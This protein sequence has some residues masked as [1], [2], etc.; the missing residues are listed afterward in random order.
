MVL[1]KYHI[2]NC[3][4]CIICETCKLNIWIWSGTLSG[5]EATLLWL[6]QRVP[7]FTATS[8]K[9]GMY[10]KCA[11]ESNYRPQRAAAVGRMSR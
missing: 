3:M 11:V 10:G 5:N 7:K 9:V 1:A 8:I 2:I 6:L 4:F